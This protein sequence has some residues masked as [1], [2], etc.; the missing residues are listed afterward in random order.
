MILTDMSVFS[1]LG[2]EETMKLP[3]DEFALLYRIRMQAYKDIDKWWSS[4]DRVPKCSRCNK[5]ISGPKDLRRI[6]GA[7]YHP[8][9]FKEQ[10]EGEKQKLRG[11]EPYLPYFERAAK[12]EFPF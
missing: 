3:D 6:A 7:S 4:P 9:C 1:E 8:K 10:L 5:E 2:I 12:L 11:K